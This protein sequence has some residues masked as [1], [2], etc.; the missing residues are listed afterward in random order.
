MKNL[1]GIPQGSMKKN[2]PDY[3]VRAIGLLRSLCTFAW[4]DILAIYAENQLPFIDRRA[5]M[6]ILTYL[7]G[8]RKEDEA[9]SRKISELINLDPQATDEH[10]D[11]IAHLIMRERYLI[12]HR[13]E[14]DSLTYEDIF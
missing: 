14:I 1:Q 10:I 11:F 3:I 6:E 9:V 13:I 2:Q 7:S 5:V 8:I 12:R 4:H